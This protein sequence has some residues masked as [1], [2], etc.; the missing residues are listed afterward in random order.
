[1]IFYPQHGI[2]NYTVF[3]TLCVEVLT[4]LF[5]TE[6]PYTFHSCLWSFFTDNY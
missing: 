3:H 6:I 2:E 1:M 4:F 5:S